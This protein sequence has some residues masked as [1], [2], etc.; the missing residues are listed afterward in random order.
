M[1]S[2]TPRRLLA[3]RFQSRMEDV[4]T[5]DD[6]LLYREQGMRRSDKHEPAGRRQYLHQSA[7]DGKM[8]PQACRRQ[9][10]FGQPPW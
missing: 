6:D 8:D 1:T 3:A 10:Q 2:V 7:A 9:V 4:L 5:T